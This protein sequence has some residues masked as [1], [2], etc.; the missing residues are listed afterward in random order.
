MDYTDSARLTFWKDLS[1]G[2]KTAFKRTSVGE[3]MSRADFATG[4]YTVVD[5]IIGGSDAALDVIKGSSKA[6]ESVVC[7]PLTRSACSKFCEV[8]VKF[9]PAM[10]ESIYSDGK[11]T[12]TAIEKDGK[13]YLVNN[14]GSATEVD[15]ADKYVANLNK[16]TGS[17]FK[18][19]AEATSSLDYDTYAD[20]YYLI[21]G[22]KATP[23][24]ALRQAYKLDILT[25]S[26]PKVGLVEQAQWIVDNPDAP[27]QY[28]GRVRKAQ[29]F[30]DTVEGPFRGG[31][32]LHPKKA[33][34]VSYDEFG[35]PI[36]LEELVDSCNRALTGTGVTVTIVNDDIVLN[37][38]A[39][40]L[41]A[42]Q[43]YMPA[44]YD[45][46]SGGY[47][48]D[49]EDLVVYAPSLYDD[50]DR[51]DLCKFLTD[52]VNYIVD[53]APL[54]ATVECKKSSIKESKSKTAEIDPEMQALDD[55]HDSVVARCR[56]FNLDRRV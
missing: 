7:S 25:D 20:D 44:D 56:V 18:K 39:D 14:D 51:E 27:E 53:N 30:L 41:R 29:K 22:K 8:T 24:D 33:E 4:T 42:V 31:K 2:L 15:D 5:E 35:L 50:C 32:L 43:T 23:M 54:V 46:F 47:N 1:Q 52:A 19:T 12:M 48:P 21:N 16:T 37:G 3:A 55:F 38:A 9:D 34:A 17:G 40:I 13:K 6:I 26:S 36:E 28:P 49:T 45:E 11:T 10:C